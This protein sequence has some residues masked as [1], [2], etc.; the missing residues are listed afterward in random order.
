MYIVYITI[1]LHASEHV[2]TFIS[3]FE[4]HFTDMINVRVILS[5]GWLV[6][7]PGKAYTSTICLVEGDKMSGHACRGECS[8][9]NTRFEPSPKYKVT[10]YSITHLCSVVL[11]I[12]V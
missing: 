3:S 6:Q 9:N 8:E 1:E 11:G 10:L 2:L 12:Y 7:C 5:S 4:G